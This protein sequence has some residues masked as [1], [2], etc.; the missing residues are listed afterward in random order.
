MFHVLVVDDEIF[1]VEAV[2]SAIDWKYLNVDE[3][4]SAYDM[5][6]AK[7]IFET[8]K[9][10]VMVCDI[11]MPNGSGIDLASWVKEYFPKTVCL[12]LTCHSD[13]QYAKEAVSLGAFEYLLKPIEYE[14]LQEHLSHALSQYQ[15]QIHLQAGNDKW[16]FHHEIVEDR[17]WS[18]LLL[19]KCSLEPEFL[20]HDAKKKDIS[21]S[22][23]FRYLPVLAVIQNYEELLTS[24]YGNDLD[25]AFRNIAYELFGLE[26][27]SLSIATTSSN[28]RV[29]LITTS[30]EESASEFENSNRTNKIRSQVTVFAHTFQK[31]F[32]AALSVVIG[33]EVPFSLLPKEYQRLSKKAA[34]SQY[35]SADLS[36]SDLL[37][38]PKF[39]ELHQKLKLWVEDIFSNRPDQ[40]LAEFDRC[41]CSDSKNSLQFYDLLF[42]A[43]FLELLKRN[44]SA[45]TIFSDERLQISKDQITPKNI[46]DQIQ[47]LCLVLFEKTQ[48]IFSETTVIDQVKTYISH[49]LAEDLSRE[50]LARQFFINPNYLSRLFK[51]ETGISLQDYLLQ[52]RIKKA[53]FLLETT[54]LSVSEVHEQSGFSHSSYFSKIFKRETGMTPLE[55]RR[56]LQGV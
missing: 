24:W 32:H 18:D 42:H 50:T 8:H 31:Y 30:F 11:E 52:E 14:K 16:I 40:V 47:I 3:V 51:K 41:F 12:F 5:E 28:E 44:I 49:H 7:K 22:E 6:T 46:R 35:F 36:A 19:G 9:I 15:K 38:N 25:F 53:R 45:Y 43:V 55:Y 21:L 54:Q 34:S 33:K 1:S 27:F 29:L 56:A 17:F 2:L 13:F 39:A 4:F 37:I 10:D 26:N 48:K 20:L 23:S